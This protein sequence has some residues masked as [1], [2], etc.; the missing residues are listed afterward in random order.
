M[1]PSLAHPDYSASLPRAVKRFF[2][3]WAR[4]KGR[5][6]RR[7]FWWVVLAGVLIT[8]AFGLLRD[9][10]LQYFDSDSPSDRSEALH[11]AATTVFDITSSS[12]SL[13]VLIPSLALLW[14]RLHDAGLPGPCAFYGLIPIVGSIIVFF[15]LVTRSRPRLVNPVWE[16]PEPLGQRRE[17]AAPPL[18]TYLVTIQILLLIA[19][20]I[21]AIAGMNNVY[22]AHLGELSTN[23]T[24]GAFNYM[25]TALTFGA[26][27][28]AVYLV[29]SFSTV[30]SRNMRVE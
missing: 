5:S 16:E 20:I 10:V 17:Y 11:S 24:E 25:T 29:Y 8:V 2:T 9:V 1:E 27:F 15:M 14:R 26:C 18:S 3:R 28:V 7:E 12:F 13:V 23:N 21:N 19:T 22:L 6:S 4:F 30:R